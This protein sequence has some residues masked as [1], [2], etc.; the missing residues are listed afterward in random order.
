VI[1]VDDGSTDRTA[2]LAVAQ[3]A[4]VVR[5]ER[6]SGPAAARNAGVTAAKGVIVAIT[7]DDC[8][9]AD[10]WLAALASSFSDPHT[11]GVGGRVLAAST[12]GFLLRYLAARQPLAPINVELLASNDL[13]YRLRLYLRSVLRPGPDL[14]AGA[15][16]YSVPGANMA[17][18]RELLLE[19]GGFDEAFT[20]AGE[21]DDLCHRAHSRP[22]GTRLRYE[23]SAVVLHRFERSLR[24]T[25][26]RSRAYGN[27][28]ARLASK[29]PDVRLI[30]Y[31]F[32][33]AVLMAI[34]AAALTRRKAPA[35]LGAII[36][37]VGYARWPTL[38][39]RT[40]SLEPLAYPFLQLAEETWM[41]LGEL[42]GRRA[43][44]AP[45]P[46]RQLRPEQAAASSR[47]SNAS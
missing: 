37:L 42:E 43:G 46:S 38:S 14:S 17:F 33:I 32:P 7:D 11:D 4:R 23:P 28:N 3:G 10:S 40:R 8:E 2:E 16:L 29:H 36:P 26:R 34:M 30:V 1:V 6:N 13:G 24:D 22:G 41:M 47:T 9:P 31:P 39:W 18:R 44:Y 45:V 21:D 27:G 15:D 19:L 25:L 35:V 5:L 20:F 12:D